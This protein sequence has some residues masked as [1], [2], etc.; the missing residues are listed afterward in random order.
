MFWHAYCFT[1][2][3]FQNESIPAFNQ[4]IK[5]LSISTHGTPTNHNLLLLI[6]SQRQVAF[7]H[8]IHLQ[9]IKWIN[10]YTDK[11]PTP[12]LLY[13]YAKNFYC[14]ANDAK[15]NIKKLICQDLFFISIFI[16]KHT[17]H[18]NG[19]RKGWFLSERATDVMTE[20]LCFLK[21]IMFKI[22]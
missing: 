9:L 15:W 19:K 13:L 17:P 1:W 16:A 4:M 2:K 14:C 10:W 22:L 20:N 21:P 18:Q 7:I 3:H 11:P 5:L 6:A 12:P 8:V